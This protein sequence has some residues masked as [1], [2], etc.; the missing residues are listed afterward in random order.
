MIKSTLLGRD[1][2]LL[3]DVNLEWVDCLLRDD[4]M[5]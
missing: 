4:K 2:S 3:N 1:K 5:S